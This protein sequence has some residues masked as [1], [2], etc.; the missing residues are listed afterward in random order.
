[1]IKSSLLL[2]ALLMLSPNLSAQEEA[3]P[4]TDQSSTEYWLNRMVENVGRASEFD[5]QMTMDM[6]AMQMKMTMSGHMLI[7]DQRHMSGSMAMDMDMPMVP[8]GKQHMDMV[9]I[10]D[11][12]DMWIEIEM[13]PNPMGGEEPM[14]QVVKMSFE[15]I[16]KM[17]AEA[18]GSMGFNMG[19]DPTASDMAAQA[20]EMFQT[21]FTDVSVEVKDG[22]G[23]LTGAVD[24]SDS[25]MGQQFKMLGIDRFTYVVDGKT[26]YPVLTTMGNEE[27]EVMRQEI[28]NLKFHNFKKMDMKAFKYQVPEGVNVMDM[29]AM[30]G[31]S[32]GGK[33]LEETVEE[34]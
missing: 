4:T 21:M 20:A 32:A 5:M 8:S 27:G 22:N 18:T 16:E 1:M 34:F 30:L 7:G 11:G 25:A 3:A 17:G 26:G 31:A 14:V 23:H 6:A 29:S 10:G 9:F 13:T 15:V 24:T 2:S 28:S 19:F 12:T 33:F